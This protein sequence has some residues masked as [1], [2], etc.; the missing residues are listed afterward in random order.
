M[1]SPIREVNH[2]FV[3]HIPSISHLVA[4][5]VIRWTVRAIT[6]LVFKSPLFYLMMVPKRE[7]S[8]AGNSIL[9]LLC[10]IVVVI[11]L[12]TQLC[13]TLCYP[14]DSS[15][16]GSS[17]RG[18]LQASIL[19]WIAI[20]FSRGSSQPREWT[21]VSC[22]AGRLFYCLSYRE[23][24]LYLIYKLNFIISVYTYERS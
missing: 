20:P 5:S 18:I 6:V 2:P 10:L 21:W 1:K 17:V 15:P 24:L 19:E 3:P 23:E 9:L 8:N 16:P 13:L 11:V 7:G 4:I 12:V 22:V 14:M